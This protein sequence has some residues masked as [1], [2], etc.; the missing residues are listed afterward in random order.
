M[1]IDYKFVSIRNLK[2]IILTA[3]L[4]EI[5]DI[6]SAID[7]FFSEITDGLDSKLLNKTIVKYP[8]SVEGFPNYTYLAA[9]STSHIAVSTYISEKEK[10]IDIEMAWC[11]S[12]DISKD[13][14]IKLIKKHF[15][16]KRYKYLKL[17][18]KGRI[19]DEDGLLD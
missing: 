18:Y 7:S 19:L 11:S 12:V 15:D 6:Y 1:Q 9:L 16:I 14:F 8:S 3:E 17:D 2:R 10:Y 5:K 4:S 13:E